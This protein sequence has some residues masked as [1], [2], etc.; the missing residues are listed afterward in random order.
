[1]PQQLLVVSQMVGENQRKMSFSYTDSHTFH[2]EVHQN[3]NRVTRGHVRIMLSNI[4]TEG[5]QSPPRVV[6]M[7][8]MM[9]MMMMMNIYTGIPG[10]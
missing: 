1:M 8:M 3:C 5:S 10:T 6:E 2:N 9:M 4:Y 7:M